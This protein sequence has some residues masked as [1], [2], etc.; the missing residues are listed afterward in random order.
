[1]MQHPEVTQFEEELRKGRRALLDGFLNF[2]LS[3]LLYSTFSWFILR[4]LEQ[5]DVV[6]F[7]FNWVEIAGV[8]CAAQFV[9]IWDRTFMRG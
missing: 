9:R 8:V 2:L 6:S 3:S 7:R 5:N 1:M 4:T